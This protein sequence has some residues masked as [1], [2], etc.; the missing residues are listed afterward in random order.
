MRHVVTVLTRTFGQ[1][2]KPKSGS[3]T[4][5]TYKKLK[6]YFIAILPSQMRVAYVLVLC[7]NDLLIMTPSHRAQLQTFFT[8]S[9]LRLAA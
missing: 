4:Q 9:P 6:S 2:T 3:S 7:Q 1:S 8:I 5:E